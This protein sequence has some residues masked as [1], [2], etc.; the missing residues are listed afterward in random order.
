MLFFVRRSRETPLQFKIDSAGIV[1]AAIGEFGGRSLFEGAG[2]A[3]QLGIFNT[4]I[5]R[6]LAGESNPSKSG[7]RSTHEHPTLNEVSV[8]ACSMAVWLEQLYQMA[9]NVHP[10]AIDILALRLQGFGPRDIAEDLD[11]GQRLVHCVLS[12]MREDR[13]HATVN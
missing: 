13:A 7:L 9:R 12:D 3:Q 8:P 1:A 10:Q 11:L 5:R 2:L 6:A 4:L